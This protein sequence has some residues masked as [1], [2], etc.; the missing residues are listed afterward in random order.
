MLVA[1]VALVLSLTGTAFAAITVTGAMIRNGTITSVDVRDNSLTSRDVRNGSLLAVDL[2]AS[3]RAALRGATGA[4]GA[5]GPAGPAGAGGATAS[6]YERTIGTVA[7]A[8]LGSATSVQAATIDV[9]VRSR[10]IATGTV[11]FKDTNAAIARF[12]GGCYIGHAPPGGSESPIGSAVQFEAEVADII[13][14]TVLAG[15]VVDPGSHVVRLRCF[16]D[17]VRGPALV[18]D[19]SLAVIA[20]AS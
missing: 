15:T 11:T 6:A 13:P 7:V 5:T 19:R 3:T 1:L 18:Q 4:T 2:S 9:S 17:L 14:V 10:L 20:T 8:Q 16:D 12:D